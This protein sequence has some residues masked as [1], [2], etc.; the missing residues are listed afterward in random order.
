M[1]NLEGKTAVVTGAASGI[2]RALTLSLLNEGAR[3]AAADRD[4]GGLEETLSL[5]GEKKESMKT[6][7]LDVSD[8]EAFESFAGNVKKDFGTVSIVINNAG[9][10]HDGN[11]LHTSYEDMEWIFGINY[12]GVVYGTRAFL[13]FLLEEEEASL[14]NISSLF[15]LVGVRKQSAYC[16]TK[17]AVRGFTESMRMELAATAVAVSVVHPGGIKTNIVRNARMQKAERQA[18]EKEQEKFAA[19]FDRIA[20]ITPE[21]AAAV[22]ISGIKK[23]KARILIGRDAKTASFIQRLFPA[24]YEKVFARIM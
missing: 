8:R 11:F 12:W 7:I 5:A 4:K 18:T 6:Y 1:K 19:M 3:V 14:V 21:E 22:I 15:G 2:G 24:G 9:V 13:P 10:N 16:A 20:K 23:K 17:F